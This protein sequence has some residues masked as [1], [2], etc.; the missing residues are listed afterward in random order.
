MSLFL[1]FECSTCAVGMRRCWLF[2][3]ILPGVLR[4]GITCPAT[5]LTTTGGATPGTPSM[6]RADGGWSNP[7]GPLCRSTPRWES[8]V[9]ETTTLKSRFC[10][11]RFAYRF[12]WP[13]C[14]CCW[15]FFQ[16]REMG[17]SIIAIIWA[18][19]DTGGG[20][21]GGIVVTKTRRVAFPQF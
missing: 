11:L 12:S 3:I 19:T 17:L 7:T 6:W 15:S 10:N 20:G 14:A 8:L 1:C 13:F 18:V 5:S 16:G 4:R 9:R 2:I 21:E